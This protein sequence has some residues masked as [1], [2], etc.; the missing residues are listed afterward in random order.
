MFVNDLNLPF[1]S[2]AYF[3]I[4]LLAALIILGLRWAVRKGQAYARTGD[5]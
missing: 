1:N 3:F 4:V 5:L 2:G